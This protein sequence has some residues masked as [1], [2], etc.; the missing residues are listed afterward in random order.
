MNEHGLS[1]KQRRFLQLWLSGGKSNAECVRLAGYQC[2]NVTVA[3]VTANRL[4]KLDKSL[5]YLDY[6][7]S[8]DA[9]SPAEPVE[10]EVARA[11]AVNRQTE[12]IAVRDAKQCLEELNRLADD[13][14]AIDDP[15]DRIREKRRTLND[16][17]KH[18]EKLAGADD[19]GKKED[20]LAAAVS[21]MIGI[22]KSPPPGDDRE[23]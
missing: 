5:K 15:V 22:F 16:L 20:T 12:Q 18:S 2:A 17:L 7:R 10:I 19:A 21:A 9:K 1:D 6:L 8:L 23:T 13:A 14:D 4:L 3:S 11:S